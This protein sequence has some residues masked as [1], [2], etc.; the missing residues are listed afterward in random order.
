MK[1]IAY[2]FPGQGSQCVGM[3]QSLYENFSV[4][5]EIYNNVSEYIGKDI[6][7]ICFNGPTEEL[8]KTINS[9]P[10]IMTTSIA[11]LESLNSVIDIK[12]DFVAGHS[13][14]EYSALYASKVLDLKTVS[15]AIAKR[16]EFM[17]I[18]AHK[19]KG[20]M[21]A[22]LNFDIEHIKS[23]INSVLSTKK[24]VLQIA[25]YNT[26][27]QTVVTGE[28]DLI[29]DLYGELLKN[30]AKR[31]VQLAVSGG[32]HSDLMK[33][34][35]TD[36]K[37]Y[38]DNIK[39]NNAV[40]PVLTNVDAKPETDGNIIKEKLVSQIYSS[41]Y[42]VQSINYMIENGVDTFVEFGAGR[43]LAGMNKKINSDI[44]TYNVFDAESLYEVKEVLSKEL[45]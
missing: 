24:G 25:N 30:G 22:V 43:V 34:A 32:F 19:T 11:A 23:C 14:G 31:V 1:K 26:P 39:F 4:A 7:N 45:V 8:C 6:A 27:V 28:E 3:G 17:D 20:G 29:D 37:Q 42:W 16:A 15:G 10:A 12:P 18:E 40:C 33:G 21:L 35:C 9:Q 13:L 36:F 2:I 41:V 5:K 38:L 44:T